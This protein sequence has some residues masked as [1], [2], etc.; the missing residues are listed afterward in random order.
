MRKDSPNVLAFLCILFEERAEW[1]VCSQEDQQHGSRALNGDKAV[2][3]V[4]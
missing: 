4:R 1:K 3:F 2:V